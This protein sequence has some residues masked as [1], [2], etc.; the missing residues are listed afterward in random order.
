MN[1]KVGDVEKQ[2]RTLQNTYAKVRSTRLGT[3]AQTVSL[4]GSTVPTAQQSPWRVTPFMSLRHSIRVHQR[5]GIRK[6]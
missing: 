3:P 6:L 4:G 5:C 2:L 1:R